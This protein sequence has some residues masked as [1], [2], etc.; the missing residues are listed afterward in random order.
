MARGA[1]V[2]ASFPAWAVTLF[3]E[4]VEKTSSAVYTAMVE[5]Q[6]AMLNSHSAGLS[7]KKF[8]AGSAR[9]TN[10]Y[11]RLV[12]HIR[13]LGIE[14]T[15]VVSPGTWYELVLV[16]N[17]LLYPIRVDDLPGDK[18]P[19]KL[20]AVVQELFT[21]VPLEGER[22]VADTFQGMEASE[23]DLR[24][25]L[26]ELAQRDPRPSLVLIP[27]KMNLSGLQQVWWGQAVLL[28]KTGHLDWITEPSLL[29]AAPTVRPGLAAQ[30]WLGEGG[31]ASGEPPT[32]SLSTRT[33]AERLGEVPPKTESE[34]DQVDVAESD[35]N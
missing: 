27:Y 32:P 9:M 10:Q 5:T 33:D 4:D 3:G 14:G 35:E 34:I 22:W 26:A 2:D 11:E 28:D 25:S 18:W 1:D 15:E 16:H 31:F 24:R 13:N 12:E 29:A 17:A 30:Q 23:L 20:S 19:R 8:T 6:D 7:K 21:F